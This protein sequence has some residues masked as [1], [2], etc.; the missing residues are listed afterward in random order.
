[1]L[2]AISH[3]QSAFSANAQIRKY[4]NKQIRKSANK[5]IRYQQ[6]AI[7]NQLSLQMR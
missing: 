1:L 5:Q 2:S 3:Q 7:S 6:S 4:A